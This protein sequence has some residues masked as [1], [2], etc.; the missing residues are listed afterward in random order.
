MSEIKDVH[1][2]PIQKLR[3]C[4]PVEVGVCE[5]DIKYRL[6]GR[7][8]TEDMLREIIEQLEHEYIKL[9]VDADGVPIRCGDTMTVGGGEIEVRAV[10]IGGFNDAPLFCARDAHHV[11]LD[12]VESVLR[13]FYDLVEPSSNNVLITPDDT[14]AKYAERIRKVVEYDK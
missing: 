13:E 12:T 3:E 4:L 14:I 6:R 11:R 7:S 5:S 1:I 8:L 2:N 10:G 9:P